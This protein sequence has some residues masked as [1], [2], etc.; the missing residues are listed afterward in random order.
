MNT[1]L[2]LSL[3]QLFTSQF[4][5]QVFSGVDVSIKSK[6]DYLYRIHRF[7]D[8]ILTSGVFDRNTLLEFKRSISLD[9]S[10]TI[11]TKNKYLIVAKIYCQQLYRMGVL[12]VD[13]STGVKLFRV[14]SSYKV[15]GFTDSEVSAIIYKMG[16]IEDIRLKTILAL[17][18]FSG[19]RDI[20]ITR[21]R[22]EH[23]NLQDSIIHVHS[24]GLNDAID[25]LP[26]VPQVKEILSGYLE[27]TGKKSGFLFTSDSRRNK[28]EGL[29]V[30]TVWLM[31]RGFLDELGISRSC[32]SFRG[33]FATELVK[34]MSNLFDVAIY[35]RHKSISTLQNYVNQINKERTLPKYY[36]AFDGVLVA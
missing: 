12:K 4:I 6:A 20:E 27:V 14:S 32:H 35:T 5:D 24:K 3:N 17:K 22:V 26:I 29:T 13:I 10:V 11:A 8:F 7:Q 18:M 33:Y 15:N 30:K 2:T 28:G 34:K 23:L 36:S 16:T 25:E 21:L 9:S 19:L 31:V 1:E